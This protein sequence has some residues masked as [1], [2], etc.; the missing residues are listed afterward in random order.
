MKV[1]FIDFEASA[2]FG[3]PIEMGWS[4]LDTN[5]SLITSDSYLIH[6]TDEWLGESDRWSPRSEL[7]H[8]ISQKQLLDEGLDVKDVCRIADETLS[9][10]KAY[11][12]DPS[13]DQR[14]A[15]ELFQAAG[16]KREFRILGTEQLF[17]DVN[18]VIKQRAI[19]NAT[20]TVQY[21]HRARGD[22]E[23]SATVWLVFLNGGS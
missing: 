6:P 21:T 19:K 5:T 2:F 9:G 13:Y 14:W 17:A 3:Y 7:V 22:C 15:D 23:F 1:T 20:S 18:P 16:M 12:T 10:K 4:T 8:K 11:A